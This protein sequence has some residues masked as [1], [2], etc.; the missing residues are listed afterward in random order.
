MFDKTET[1]VLNKLKTWG[2]INANVRALILTS[3][4][5]GPNPKP[6]K[7]SDYDIEVIVDDLGPFNNDEWLNTFGTT[8]VKWP[9][10]PKNTGYNKNSITRLVVFTDFPRVDFQIMSKLSFDSFAYDSGYKFIVDKDNLQLTTPKP[11]CTEYII[12][13]P[14]ADVFYEAIDGF[15]WDLPY[16]AK[17]LKRGE[18]AFARFMLLSA[19][20]YDSF[21]EM[22]AWYIGFKN[23]WTVNYGA[24]GRNF[25]KLTDKTFANEINSLDA[26]DNP[27]LIWRNALKMEQL[28]H[29]MY[30]ELAINLQYDKKPVNTQAVLTYCNKILEL[31]LAQ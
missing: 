31:P 17:S 14:S 15:Y 22:L 12:K 11:T 27:E 8:L 16:I 20:R 25:E 28:F 21:D 10:Y 24:H 3:S 1:E 4:R 7:L 9:L 26:G 18:L 2:D 5:V 19:I 29:K 6:D 13:Q 23:S 30:E